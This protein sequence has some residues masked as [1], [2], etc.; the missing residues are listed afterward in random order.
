MTTLYEYHKKEYPPCDTVVGRQMVRVRGVDSEQKKT[1]K[2]ARSR[3]SKG[4]GGV[5]DD[6][7]ETDQGC[8]PH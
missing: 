5:D 7:G 8:G 6:H 3:D 2:A 4:G 1:E